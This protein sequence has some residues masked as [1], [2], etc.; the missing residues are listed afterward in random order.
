VCESREALPDMYHIGATCTSATHHQLNSNARAS[1]LARKKKTHTT[2]F[3]SENPTHLPST[4][5]RPAPSSIHH[6]PKQ[7]NR[8]NQSHV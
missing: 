2:P 4:P 7:S 1:T 3:H 8:Q 6:P 5:S